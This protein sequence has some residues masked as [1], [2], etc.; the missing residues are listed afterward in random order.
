MITELLKSSV[1]RLRVLGFIE[2]LSLILLIAVGMPLK[3]G[4]DS[5][6]LVKTLGPI[7]GILFVLFV[8][9][10][11]MVSVEARWKFGQTTWK[12][13]LSSFIP[14]GNFYVDKYILSKLGGA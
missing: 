14:F 2:G 5:P 12:V 7:H 8:V 13:L 1:G 9:Y 3:Y 6:G 4:M 11:I 10:T